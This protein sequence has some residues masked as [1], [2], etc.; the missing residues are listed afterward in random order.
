MGS[1]L[2]IIDTGIMGISGKT[3]M[4]RLKKVLCFAL[5]GTLFLFTACGP[6]YSRSDDAMADRNAGI[7][8]TASAA[9]EQ[10]EADRN[11]DPDTLQ[12]ESEAS[13]TETDPVITP[14]DN[15]AAE[16]EETEMSSLKEIPSSYYT[17]SEKGGTVARLDYTTRSYDEK[18]ET[19]EK[20]AFVYLPYEYDESRQYNVFYMLHGGGGEMEYFFGGVGG[21][22]RFK[23]LIDNMIANG[24]IDPLIVVTPTYYPMERTNTQVQN[25]GIATEKFHFELVNDLIPAV[26]GTYSTYAETTD[27]EDLKASRDHRAFGG[28]SMGSVASWYTFIYCLDEFRYYM[29]MSGDCWAVTQMG[30][31]THGKETAEYLENAFQQSGH[32]TQD[33]FIYT[34]TGNKDIAFEALDNQIKSMQAYAPSFKFITAENP[35]GNICYRL[36]PDG[37]HDYNYIEQYIYN[38]LPTF[39]SGTAVFPEQ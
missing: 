30:G 34:L 9:P 10:I 7:S 27:R 26:E 32:G 37:V 6:A 29:P 5:A 35:E 8:D 12:P 31:R 15:E 14:D 16:S 13:D 20:Y 19:L 33:F 3:L 4:K 18:N 39:W 1:K 36:H 21:S 17:K 22:T 24:D 38:A 2:F 25:A 28:F 11:D 23:N